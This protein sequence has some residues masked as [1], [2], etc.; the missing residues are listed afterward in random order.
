MLI[1][2]VGGSGGQRVY[3]Y[4]DG[5]GVVLGGVEDGP[6]GLMLGV[7]GENMI[8]VLPCC[9]LKWAS[10]T[11]GALLTPVVGIGLSPVATFPQIMNHE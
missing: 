10:N 11:V 8:P 7:V 2:V 9:V 4:R 1:G 5:Q 6:L 3:S